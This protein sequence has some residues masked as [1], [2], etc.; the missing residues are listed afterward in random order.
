[1]STFKSLLKQGIVK[2]SDTCN[3]TD[4]TPAD[5]CWALSND[6]LAKGHVLCVSYENAVDMLPKLIIDAYI[7]KHNRIPTAAD[8]TDI[9]SSVAQSMKVAIVKGKL[10]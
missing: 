9:I 6:K 4:D 8:L 10:P 7:N 2:K 3:F 5:G 1:M